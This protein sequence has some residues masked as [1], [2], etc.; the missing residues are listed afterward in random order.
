MIFWLN[1]FDLA[2]FARSSP[3]VPKYSKL[4]DGT[5]ET[6][7]GLVVPVGP[8]GLVDPAGPDDEVWLVQDCFF[9]LLV[10]L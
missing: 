4:I 7:D 9:V 5:P 3:F 10:V 1:L 6:T 8:V 2:V